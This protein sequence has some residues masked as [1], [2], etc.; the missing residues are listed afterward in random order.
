MSLGALTAQKAQGVR[1]PK[2]EKPKCPKCD[3]SQ[4]YYRMKDQMHH[5]RVCGNDWP[6]KPASKKGK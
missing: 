5:C 3:S 2:I 4:N 6:A 1:M